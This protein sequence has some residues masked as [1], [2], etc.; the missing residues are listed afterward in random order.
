MENIYRGKYSTPLLGCSVVCPGAPFKIHG[1]IF[2]FLQLSNNITLYQLT[3]ICTSLCYLIAL[4]QC[5]FSALSQNLQKA[6]ITALMKK[7][8]WRLPWSWIQQIYTAHMET[9]CRMARETESMFCETGPPM[10]QARQCLYSTQIPQETI[11]YCREYSTSCFECSVIRPGALFKIYVGTVGL[12][13]LPNS[14]HF[15]HF[16]HFFCGVCLWTLTSTPTHCDSRLLIAVYNKHTSV[17]SFCTTNVLFCET[18]PS[19]LQ[20]WRCLYTAWISQQS[21]THHRSCSTPILKYSV[22]CP[23]APF[24]LH[25]GIVGFRQLSDNIALYQ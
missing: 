6:Y 17:K 4:T 10:L 1:A 18:E 14:V 8:H 7:G 25:V 13:N 19:L 16:C 15:C 23:G 11:T 3:L 21:I 20:P 24:K 5:A 9:K 12:L 2:G 22:L